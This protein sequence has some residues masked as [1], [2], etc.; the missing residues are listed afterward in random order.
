VTCL[1]GIYDHPEH[2]E[3]VSTLPIT[4][5]VSSPGD[6]DGS[7]KQFL[8]RRRVV[9]QLWLLLSNPWWFRVALRCLIHVVEFSSRIEQGIDIFP[10]SGS[11]S[12]EVSTHGCAIGSE[13]GGCIVGWRVQ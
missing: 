4:R 11:N 9:A 13:T 3:A 12:A 7:D 2:V 8:G 1:I 5:E 6:A 10:M